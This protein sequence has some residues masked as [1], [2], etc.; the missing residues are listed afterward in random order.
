VREKDEGYQ[1]H[2]LFDRKSSTAIPG[3]RAENLTLII[4]M[5]AFFLATEYRKS[6]KDK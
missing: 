5:E 6:L 4:G 1:R 3:L 2:C